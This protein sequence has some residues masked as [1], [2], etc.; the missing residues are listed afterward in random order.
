MVKINRPKSKAVYPRHR[1]FEHLDRMR[2]LPAIWIC[3]PA[4]S[5]KTT[6]VSSYI[7]HSKIPCLWYR[8]SESDADMATF[9]WFLGQT[10]RKACSR[11]CEPLPL[12]TPEYLQGVPT[13]TQR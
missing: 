5:G 11:R 8:L 1:L 6:L 4:G 9:F 2:T 12:L 10:A 3:A 13:F 7:E